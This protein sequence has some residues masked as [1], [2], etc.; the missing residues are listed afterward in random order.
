METE[1]VH[2]EVLTEAQETISCHEK[3]TGNMSNM[4]SP[5]LWEMYKIYVSL[6][7]R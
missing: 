5:H 4:I 2:C 1:C 7:M 6:S 3:S